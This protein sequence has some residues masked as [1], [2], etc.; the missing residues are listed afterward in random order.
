ML[1]AALAALSA[2]VTVLLAVEGLY[3]LWAVAASRRPAPVPPPAPL[4]DLPR[5]VVQVPVKDEGEVLAHA[6]DAVAALDWPRDKLSAQVIDDSGPDGWAAS[7][8]LVD[9]LRAKGVAT[10]HL[11]GEPTEHKAGAL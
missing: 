7:A 10:E 3:Y 9:A 5:V 8:R 1:A 11:R 6:L 4:A 2:L